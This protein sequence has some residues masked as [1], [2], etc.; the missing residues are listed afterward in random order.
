MPDISGIVEWDDGTAI[1]NATVTARLGDQEVATTTSNADGTYTLTVAG[2][3]D[4]HVKCEY[5]DADGQY[6][7]YSYPYIYREATEPLA[8]D[9]ALH[10]WNHDEGSGTTLT[11]TGAA[12]TLADATINGGTW[13]T[14]NFQYEGASV[15]Y[16]IA[17]GDNAIAPNRDTMTGFTEG[18]TV[19]T[20][21]YPRDAS[22]RQTVSRVSS[23]WIFRIDGGDWD[24][25]L[26]DADTGDY[27]H[28]YYGDTV[29]DTNTWQR[30]GFR[31][32]AGE[33]VEV[34]DN[35]TINAHSSMG[36]QG[37]AI[38]NVASSTSDMEMP[39]SSNPIDGLIDGPLMVWDR[40][41]SDSEIQDDYDAFTA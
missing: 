40:A 3:G 17:D 30:A 8:W 29:V 7:T 2:G 39:G 27:T 33:H 20:W 5:E 19:L 41:L 31:W 23:S 6:H 38:S 34:I 13:D 1:E 28:Y 12:G 35:S 22:T 37:T 15:D 4:Y 24:V 25:Y 26:Y 10:R 11:D 32:T 21:I 16:T 9:D 14:S 18:M 36:G